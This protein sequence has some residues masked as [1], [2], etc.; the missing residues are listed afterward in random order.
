MRGFLLGIAVTVLVWAAGWDTVA[1]VLD[2]ADTYA[3][4]A[5]S[6]TERAL[7]DARARRASQTR[8]SHESEATRP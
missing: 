2:T 1:S 5:Y 7:G 8:R 6:A 3:K 4:Q